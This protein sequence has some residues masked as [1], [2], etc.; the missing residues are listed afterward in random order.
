MPTG[1][2]L[3]S[4]IVYTLQGHKQKSNYLGANCSN[5]FRG[6]YFRFKGRVKLGNDK[7]NKLLPER[8]ILF[9]VTY[10]D[11]VL[12][13]NIYIT[14]TLLHLLGF[15]KIKTNVFFNEYFNFILCILP[16][17]SVLTINSH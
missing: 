11:Y 1:S 16:V 10:M 3:L 7:I 12:V 6:S 4:E 17:Y 14:Y 8:F 9:D 2:N 13:H 5:E 15:L